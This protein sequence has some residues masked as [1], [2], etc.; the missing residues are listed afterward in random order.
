MLIEILQI[1][2]DDKMIVK[3]IKLQTGEFP[4]SMPEEGKK[5]Q[6]YPEEIIIEPEDDFSDS[7]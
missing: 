5:Y 1:L 6:V 2:P 7:Q 3:L 4:E